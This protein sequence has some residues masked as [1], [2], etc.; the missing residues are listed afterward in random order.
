MILGI[1][2]QI[3]IFR[4]VA[5][6]KYSDNKY[7]WSWVE[8]TQYKSKYI[9]ERSGAVEHEVELWHC[10]EDQPF[11]DDWA[12]LLLDRSTEC[13]ESKQYIQTKASTDWNRY[14][15]MYDYHC[16]EYLFTLTAYCKPSFVCCLLISRFLTRCW[17]VVFLFLRG[18]FHPYITV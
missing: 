1:Q 12:K 5:S 10:D 2:S 3:N 14:S 9:R 18:Q 8:F 15:T 17:F 11:L 7:I 13:V 6:Q 4:T 16:S